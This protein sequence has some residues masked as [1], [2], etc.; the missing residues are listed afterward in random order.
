MR[1]AIPIMLLKENIG[2]NLQYLEIRKDPL[3]SKQWE[4][5]R[6]KRINETNYIKIKALCSLRDT[7]KESKGNQEVEIQYLYPIEDSPCDIYELFTS[8]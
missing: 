5:K 8:H 6:R 1:R 2:E 4:S 3:N 7:M